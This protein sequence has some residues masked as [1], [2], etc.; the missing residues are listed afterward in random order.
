M[1][2]YEESQCPMPVCTGPIIVIN[3]AWSIIITIGYKQHKIH[4]RYIRR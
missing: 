1:L 2:F 3:I 4:I